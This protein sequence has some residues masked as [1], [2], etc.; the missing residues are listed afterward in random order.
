MCLAQYIRTVHNMLD[1]MKKMNGSI[2]QCGK[3]HNFTADIHTGSGAIKKLADALK[4]YASQKVYVICDENTKK[5]GLKKVEAI[6]NSENLPYSV[7]VYPES[8]RPDEYG[9][10]AAVMN[11]PCDCDTVIAIGSGVINDIGKMLCAVGNKTYIIV[12]TAPSMDGYA[13]TTSSVSRSGLKT[14]VNTKSAEVIIGDS[15][16]VCTAPRKMMISGLGD[17]LAKYISICEWRL[18]NLITGEYYCEQIANLIRLA[19]KKCVSVA[20]RLDGTD[21]LAAEALFEGLIIGSV[22]M[23]YA[24][25]S[26]P[27]SGVEHYI[28]HVID[29]RAEEFDT[30]EDLHGIQCAIG[31]YLAAKLYEKIKAHTPNRDKALAYAESFDLAD[32]NRRLEALLGKGAES[33]IKLEEK[34]R[35]YDT[36]R[37]RERFEVICK[38]W[39]KILEIINDELPSLEWLDELYDKAGIPKKV[40]D[41][42]TDDSLFPEIFRAT[43][44]IR[45]KYVLSRL[46]FDLGIIDDILE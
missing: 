41:I 9:V 39:D 20:E 12:A 2:C 34:E 30:P 42:G 23:N 17:M 4:K 35:K 14:S 7:F 11:C 38:N 3:I 6:L 40:S 29:M 31:T 26:R 44:D 25:I 28:S 22:A 18:S 32:W 24:G 43:K 10:G 8:P 33:M 36:A 15:D 37:H 45:D 21:S 16:I 13:S 27:A 46:A 19:L 1:L 5:V